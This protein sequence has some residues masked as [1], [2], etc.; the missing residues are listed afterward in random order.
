MY[1]FRPRPEPEELEALLLVL[2]RL[3]R[4]EDE[5]APSGYRSEWRRAALEEGVSSSDGAEPDN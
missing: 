3:R 1:S 5:A 2:E 4:E